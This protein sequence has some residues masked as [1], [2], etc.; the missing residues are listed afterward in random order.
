M[1][2]Y[3]LL[4]I[5]FAAAVIASVA[6]VPRVEDADSSSYR[7]MAQGE[8]VCRP[9]ASRVLHPAVARGISAA[10]VPMQMAF[11]IIMAASAVVFYVLLL[12]RLR[13]MRPVWMVFLLLASPLWWMW[14][15][16]IY[17]QD[18]FAAA[19][20]AVLFCVVS[21]ASCATDGK[22]ACRKVGL[23]LVALVLFL[24]QLTRE[25]SAVFAI[26]LAVLAW[27]ERDKPLAVVSIVAMVAGMAVV[28]WNTHDA[29][30]N[31]NELGS[32]SYMACKVVANGVRNFTGLIPWNDGYAAH[33]AFYYPDP[34]IWK[35]TLP[36]FL[37]WGNVHEIGI[38]AFLPELIAMTL[39]VW[40]FFFPG[41][42]LLL[43]P[44][45]REGRLKS[46]AHG[47][48]ARLPLDVQ[49]AIVSGGIFWV[50]APF[51]GTSLMRYVGYAWPLFWIALPHLNEKCKM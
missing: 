26:V 13:R 17:I 47:G 36:T 6:V 50:T 49:L 20:A 37:Q 22:A 11:A 18:M 27:R 14:T 28:A 35:C 21:M 31:I 8:Q 25:T 42:F 2:T 29:A 23:P 32:F 43:L 41:A 34:P 16:N 51:C 19:L 24:L 3:I 1:R 30:S 48:F 7:M 33:L 39:V 15:G 38:Y 4:A 45:C 46:L 12:V 9:Y 40:P 44:A 10:G 5:A